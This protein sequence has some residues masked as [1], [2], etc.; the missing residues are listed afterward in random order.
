[1]AFVREKLPEPQ[2]S[3]AV[4]TTR[5]PSSVIIVGGGGGALAAADAQTRRI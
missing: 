3:R 2:P 4:R 1:M 5:T